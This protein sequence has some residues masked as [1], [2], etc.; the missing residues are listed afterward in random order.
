MYWCADF[1][2]A[3]SAQTASQAQ[4]FGAG[5]LHRKVS[6]HSGVRISANMDAPTKDRVQVAARHCEVY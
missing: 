3:L 6:Q 2:T 1:D 5:C 4:Q